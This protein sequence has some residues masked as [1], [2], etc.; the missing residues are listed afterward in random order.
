M[1]VVVVMVDTYD[2]WMDSI[3]SFI[4]MYHDYV[5]VYD[6][7]HYDAIRLIYS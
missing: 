7:I 1:V 2:G 6:T 4:Q 3:E 5:Y